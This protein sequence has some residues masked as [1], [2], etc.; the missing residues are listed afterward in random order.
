MRLDPNDPFDVYFALRLAFV[1]RPEVR[2]RTQE[3]MAPPDPRGRIAPDP[4]LWSVDAYAWL[5]PDADCS[6]YLG[7]NAE[8]P[9]S[10]MCPRLVLGERQLVQ[11]GTLDEGTLPV[12]ESALLARLLYDGGLE[13]GGAAYVDPLATRGFAGEVLAGA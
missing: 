4:A 3:R 2:I 6:C 10:P 7:V 8:Y 11:P 5:E 13:G 1:D 9:C 12:G